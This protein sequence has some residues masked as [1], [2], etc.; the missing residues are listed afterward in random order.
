MNKTYR[1]IWNDFTNTW[2]A[3]SEIARARGKRA[4]GAVLLAAAGFI[5]VP[6]APTFAAPPNPPVATQLPTGGQLV[7]GQATIA[8]RVN[9]T[10]TVNQSSNRAA[11]DWQTFN[12]G[13][14]ARVNFIQPSSSAAILNRVL[15]PNP[16]Q[17]FGRI[18][19]NGQ[20]FLTNSSGI[21][22]SPTANVNVGALTATTHSISN[23]DF[24]AGRLN[25]TR[26]GAT[27][28]VINEGSLTA[29]L[30][31]YIALLAPEV[32]N[33]GVIVA[34][35]G[36]VALAA[37]EAVE[38][39]FDNNRLTNIRVEPATIA[40][41]VDNGNAVQAPGG[42][43]ILSAQAA[44][45][46]QG[47]VVNNSGSLE[48]TGLVDNGGVIRLEAS[49]RIVHSG[50]IKV[51]AA[52]GKVGAGGTATLIAS[53]AN[54]DSVTE[55]SG[56]ISARGGDLPPLQGEGRGGDGGFIET[57]GG[58]VQ[59]GADTRVDTRAPHGKTG[60]W[61]LDPDGFTIASSGGDITGAT[62]STNLGTADVSI[63]SASGSHDGTS[64]NINVNDTVAWNAHLLTLSAT[65]NININADM[66][67]TGA[68]SLALIFGQGAV[69]LNNTSNIITGNGAAVNLPA[70]TT[71]FTTLQGSDGVLKN[72]TII[73]SLGAA[74]SMT[75]TDLQGIN[76]GL[77]LNYALGGNIDASDTS[78]WNG[79]GSPTIYAGFTP[80]DTFTGISSELWREATVAASA[81]VTLPAMSPAI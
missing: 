16:S 37:G 39:Q 31:G 30:N 48:A 53:L 38:L 54:P 50:S 24:M 1:L 57:S 49:D 28:S 40:A 66:N 47:G 74:G 46:L 15:D 77:A 22:F 68:A 81:T 25:F 20:V 14:A 67:A 43:I 33:T 62:L 63:T 27:G 69:A 65:N 73:T 17:I 8:P 12:V 32:R 71:N 56:S 11:I 58:R 23:D 9:N 60:T 29:D 2:V 64:G 3:V 41:L 79:S 26:N 52:A 6:P 78:T 13:S 5:A 76:G 10:L 34:Q 7:A 36:T 44:N 75:H 4:S 42:L 35:M 18:T 80:T 51:D 70:G 59:I 55:I 19:A 45:R 21:Y 72:Y 61:L